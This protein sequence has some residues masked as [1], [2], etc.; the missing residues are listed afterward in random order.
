VTGAFMSVNRVWFER[1]GGFSP[2]YIFGH[3]EDV[4][5]CLRSLQAGTPAWLHDIPFWHLESAGGKR[6]PVHD[7][8]RLVN[9]WHLTTKWG[10]LVRTELNGRSPI[11]FEK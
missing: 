5:L 8:G 11:R 2:D 10:D 7:G 1:L 3:Y 9:R 6:E 4:D